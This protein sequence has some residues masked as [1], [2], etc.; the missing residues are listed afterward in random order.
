M[1]YKV[2]QK[3]RV[4]KDLVVGKKYGPYFF[5]KE[6]AKYS[7]LTI[8]YI[9]GN[10]NYEMKEDGGSYSWTDEMLEPLNRTLKDI[11]Y[12]DVITDGDEFI[13]ILGRV[14]EAIFVSAEAYTEEDVKEADYDIVYSL[15]E[16]IN[17]FEDYKIVGQEEDTTEELTIEEVCKQL[18]KTVKIKK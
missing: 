13:Y 4:K 10:D 14:D 11:Q 15:T 8:V 5:N 9:N 2:G 3:V 6:K 18:G 16:F 7:E 12:G 1:K 17:D